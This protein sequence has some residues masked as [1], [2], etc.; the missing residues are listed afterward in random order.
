MIKMTGWVTGT[1]IIM[2][3]FAGCQEENLAGTKK[4]RLVASENRRLKIQIDQ[5]EAEII[6]LKE[7]HR[8]ELAQ[9]KQLLEK[10]RQHKQALQEKTDEAIKE[11]VNDILVTVIE[12]NAKLREKIKALEDHIEDLENTRPFPRWPDKPQP[13]EQ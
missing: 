6:K 5:L 11:Q 8:K 10:C 2:M 9:Q 3:L 7:N 1:V 12:E 13:L 4:S